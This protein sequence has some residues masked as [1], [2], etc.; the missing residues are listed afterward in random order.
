[1]NHIL[2]SMLLLVAPMIMGATTVSGTFKVNGSPF[3][4]N[5]VVTLNY[6]GSTGSYLNLPQPSGPLHV[7]NGTFTPFVVDG[8]DTM[9]PRGTYYNVKAY[10]Q[11]NALVASLNYVVTG[12]TFDLGAAVP[13]PVNTN[14]VS[15]LDL[16]GLRN[17]S[18]QNLTV[19]NDIQMGSGT[20]LSAYGVSNAESI[21]QIR[22]AYAFATR[23]PSSTTC[24]IQEALADL[25]SSG[26][27]VML[28]NGTCAVSSTINVGVPVTLIG[29][30][31]GGYTNPSTHTSLTSPT[32]LTNNVA[33]GPVFQVQS[34]AGGALAGVSFL[35]M[36]IVQGSGTG[37]A[38]DL[39]NPSS[40]TATLSNVVIADTFIYGAANGVKVVG[41][42]D[43]L[44]IQRSNLSSNTAAGIAF[45]PG[46]GYSVTRVSVSDSQLRYNAVAGLDVA[47]S[48]TRTIALTRNNIS[49][50]TQYGVRV[51]AGSINAIL[52]LSSSLL[53]SNPVANLL[54]SDAQGHEVDGNVFSNSAYGVNV[55]TPTATNTQTASLKDNTFSSNSTADLNTGATTPYV[56]Y[57]P[58]VSQTATVLQSVPGTV[59]YILGGAAPRVCTGTYPTDSCYKVLDD[60]TV[61]EWGHVTVTFPS[62]TLATGSITFPHT[63]TAN[64]SL[65]LSANDNADGS[66]NFSVWGSSLSTSGSSVSARCAVNIGGSG[67]SGSLGSTITI[68]WHAVSY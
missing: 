38:I 27:V 51:Q 67:C 61:L 64:P 20:I 47:S 15:F 25:P 16:L 49:N 19:L 28:Q 13:T 22:Y 30:G 31:K 35:S 55:D 1:M 18:V 45:T 8:N 37:D 29:F 11:Y 53:S 36:A 24:G 48:A 14:N 3:N 44:T 52:Q 54:L 7:T 17:I 34:A 43:A 66:N 59:R 23:N 56:L 63:F 2:A 46:A 39:G 40:T 42:V 50:N 68:S 32:I 65:T 26:G 21:G 10:N 58:Q 12:A 4:G 41:N 6:P 57:Y 62:G 60:G 9:L 5:M 33:S